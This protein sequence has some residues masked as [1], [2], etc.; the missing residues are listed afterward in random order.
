[1]ADF[2]DLGNGYFLN[3]DHV[4]RVI[5]NVNGERDGS[6]ISRGTVELLTADGR[7]V[8]LYHK[9]AAILMA[10]FDQYSRQGT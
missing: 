9:E 7:T 6:T 1:M 8:T 10:Y 2:V 3:L 5:S 4:V